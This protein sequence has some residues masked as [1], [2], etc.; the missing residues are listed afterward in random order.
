VQAVVAARWAWHRPLGG[1]HVGLQLVLP[2][3]RAMPAWVT[4]YSR[5][6]LYRQVRA[7]AVMQGSTQQVR[8]KGP[9]Q[10]EWSE[11]KASPPQAQV[12]G[13]EGQKFV[14]SAQDAPEPVRPAD[15]RKALGDVAPAGVWYRALWQQDY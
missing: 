12:V 11:A 4:V 6:A 8:V 2:T 7:N 13:P 14:A 5:Q 3:E 15:P 9:R 1:Q 10:Q